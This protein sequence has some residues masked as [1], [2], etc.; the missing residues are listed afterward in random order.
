MSS[1]RVEALRRFLPAG[2]QCRDVCFCLGAVGLLCVSLFL[3]DTVGVWNH[4]VWNR[5]VWNA[6]PNLS[7]ACVL[8][9]LFGFLSS[10]MSVGRRNVMIFISLKMDVLLS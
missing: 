3:L 6:A 7:V 10:I 4:R 1:L 8:V 5:R 2:S 9:S